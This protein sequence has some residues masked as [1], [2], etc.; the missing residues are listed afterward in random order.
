MWTYPYNITKIVIANEIGT[1]FMGT[2]LGKIKA[3]QWPFTDSMKFSKY[4]TE[5]QLHSAPITELKITFDYSLLISGAEDGTIFIS[6]I[7]AIS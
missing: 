5:I 2:S 7:N 3:H 1:I 4:F 6:K